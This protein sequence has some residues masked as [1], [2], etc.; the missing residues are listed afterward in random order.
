MN[1]NSGNKFTTV[2]SIVKPVQACFCLFGRLG[3]DGEL[4]SC[5]I[6]VIGEEVCLIASH[7]RG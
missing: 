1:R 3:F 4:P 2:L 7:E 5:P 6:K